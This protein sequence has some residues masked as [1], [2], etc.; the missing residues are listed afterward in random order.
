MKV[1]LEK[2][3]VKEKVEVT[4]KKFINNKIMIVLLDNFMNQGCLFGVYLVYLGCSLG[5]SGG[6]LRC[7]FCFFLGYFMN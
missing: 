2:V 3:N 6:V 7:F 4:H 1:P 5:V